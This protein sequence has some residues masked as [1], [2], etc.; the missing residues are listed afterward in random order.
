MR[1]FD[2]ESGE[3]DGDA[4]SRYP[5]GVNPGDCYITHCVSDF[6]T[7][8]RFQSELGRVKRLIR[9]LGQLRCL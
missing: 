8:T 1:G 4:P 5:S 7:S 6:E 9:Y 3:E 2:D